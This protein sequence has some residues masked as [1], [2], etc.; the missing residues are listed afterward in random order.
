MAVW[1]FLLLLTECLIGNRFAEA[2]IFV[3]HHDRSEDD[4][5]LKQIVGYCNELTRGTA[6]VGYSSTTQIMDPESENNYA[7]IAEERGQGLK[8]TELTFDEESALSLGAEL[9]HRVI[10]HTS[11][12]VIR[13]PYGKA[14]GSA[15]SSVEHY[16]T[17]LSCTNFKLEMAVEVAKAA[18]IS[19]STTLESE[20]SYQSKPYAYVGIPGPA[21][22]EST[23]LL[24][25]KIYVLAKSWNAAK[26][27]MQDVIRLQTF[28]GYPHI[29]FGHELIHAERLWR[30]EKSERL[31]STSEPRNFIYK[32][33]AY[34]ETGPRYK[35]GK[36]TDIEFRQMRL[37]DAE[38][39]CVGLHLENAEDHRRPTFPILG[40]GITYDSLTTK[41]G[42]FCD[43]QLLR[44]GQRCITENLLRSEAG[45]PFRI[46]YSPSFRDTGDLLRK[47][48]NLF[49]LN[50]ELRAPPRQIEPT[51]QS[52]T[53][54]DDDGPRPVPISNPT[55]SVSSPRS[56]DR[57]ELD[58]PM[59]DVVHE[60][61]SSMDG[62]LAMEMPE[63]ELSS[64]VTTH[65]ETSSLL[66][67]SPIRA[68]PKRREVLQPSP[69]RVA[70]EK[71]KQST[72]LRHRSN[73]VSSARSR[74]SRPPAQR[75][76]KDVCIGCVTQDPPMNY[77]TFENKCTTKKFGVVKTVEECRA[78]FR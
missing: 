5:Y 49:E 15:S 56:V 31:V 76:K 69:I 75:T 21:L 61:Y 52:G 7:K 43:S 35:Q 13:Q 17:Q 36:L 40:H 58:G 55:P 67:P 4:D 27:E 74:Q 30:S 44:V 46:R 8:L 57:P 50:G 28:R 73:Q 45:L 16:S 59:K 51:E 65:R 77:S 47:V 23:G 25:V 41:Q 22:W 19:D 38:I 34:P 9:I 10:S 54:V 32:V 2:R 1:C 68:P 20:V 42:D 62:M 71:P 66:P 18:D 33:K 37:T 64:L 26:G 6:T 29:M 14:R 78:R 11:V 72:A 63:P 3:Q 48:G 60:T 53:T 24:D 12:L 70:P 39:G